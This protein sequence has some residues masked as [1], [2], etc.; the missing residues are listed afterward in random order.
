MS[1][2]AHS[3]RKRNSLT[4]LHSDRALQAGM[5]H[6]AG[7]DISPLGGHLQHDQDL[8][9]PVSVLNKLCGRDPLSLL[10]AI[11]EPAHFDLGWVEICHRADQRVVVVEGFRPGQGD[12]DIGPL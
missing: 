11:P 7:V 9:S 1:C 8:E 3:E 12:G 6:L 5:L 10:L 4:P 2:G